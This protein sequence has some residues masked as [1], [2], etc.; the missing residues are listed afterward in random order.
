MEAEVR[1]WMCRP[2]Q[3]V[4]RR[5]ACPVAYVPLGTLEWHG[6]HNPVGADTLQAEGLAVLCARRGGGLVLPPLYYG[7]TRSESLVDVTGAEHVEVARAMGLP[8]ENFLPDRQPFS[9][10][11]QVLNYQRLLLH[12]LAE[13]ESLGFQLGRARR[14]PLPADRPRPRRGAA[15]QQ[16]PLQQVPRHAGLDLPGLPV[17]GGPLPVRRRPRGGLGDLAPA[18]PAPRDRGPG[19]PARPRESRCWA[20]T[21]S[22]RPTR[23]APSWGGARWRSPPSRS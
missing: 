13:A 6:P 3:I 18:G 8:P 19:A 12:I 2:D 23:P 17:P 15:V 22:C 9:A 20:W 11:E 5:Q 16:A 10:T 1:Y 14:R 21:A 7:E 4:E